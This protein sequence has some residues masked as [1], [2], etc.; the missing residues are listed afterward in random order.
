M[1]LKRRVRAS[2]CGSARPQRPCLCHR[3]LANRFGKVDH[4]HLKPANGES[5]FKGESTVTTPGFAA[6]AAIFDGAYQHRGSAAHDS[7]AGHRGNVLPVSFD[8]S[9]AAPIGRSLLL[10]DDCSASCFGSTLVSTC[11]INIPGLGRTYVTFPCG[12]CIV[13]PSVALPIIT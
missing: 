3:S 9:A 11:P 2:E 10:R 1:L 5:G 12:T 4:Q 13:N 8:L 7:P 6:E